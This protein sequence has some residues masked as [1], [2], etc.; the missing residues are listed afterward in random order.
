MFMQYAN[1]LHAPSL[2]MLT[3]T[4]LSYNHYCVYFPDKDTEV[5]EFTPQI[6]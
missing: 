1:T 2:A 6:Q 4:L 5:L 3:A